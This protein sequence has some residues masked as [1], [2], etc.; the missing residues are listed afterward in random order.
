MHIGAS[1]GSLRD[2]LY[3]APMALDALI[4]L[5]GAF[6][7]AL[8]FLG[9]PNT[10]DTALFLIAGIFVITLGVVVRRRSGE[11]HATESASREPHFVEHMPRPQMNE[12]VQ[13]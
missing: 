13:S 9:L 5:T 4:M 3:T 6:V 11:L 8:P 12:H 1:I 7:A 2:W 10:W